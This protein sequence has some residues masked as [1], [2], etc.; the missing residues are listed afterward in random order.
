MG[1]ALFPLLILLLFFLV[2][3]RLVFDKR[4][5]ECSKHMNR[6]ARRCPHCGSKNDR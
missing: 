5:P 6:R 1:E 3:T 2:V 4:C